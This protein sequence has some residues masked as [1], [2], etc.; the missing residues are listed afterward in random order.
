[1]SESHSL[2]KLNN[3]LLYGYTALL[4]QSYTDEHV[5]CFHLLAVVT[6]AATNVGVQ[7]LDVP[8]M[9]N[10]TSHLCGHRASSEAVLHGD[11]P[12]V[13]PLEARSE[14]PKCLDTAAG[15]WHSCEKVHSVLPSPYVARKDSKGQRGRREGDI[16]V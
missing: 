1:M 13:F 3:I 6:N 9:Q 14:C 11:L 4:I 2:L 7:V 12:A 5:G 15:P 10:L 16:G 8:L